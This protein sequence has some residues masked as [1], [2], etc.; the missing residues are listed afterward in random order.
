MR[1]LKS[2]L[3]ATLALM[4]V[5]ALPALSVASVHGGRAFAQQSGT[6]ERGYRT[7]YSDGYQEGIRDSYDSQAARQNIRDEDIQSDRGYSPTFG[8]LE[9]DDPCGTR[10]QHRQKCSKTLERGAI[11]NARGDGN[12]R[13]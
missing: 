11:S 2:F 7:G 8:S 6:L 9:H 5:V 3:A 10:I 12:D 1:N 13:R 4:L